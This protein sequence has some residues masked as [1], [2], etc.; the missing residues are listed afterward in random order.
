[1]SMSVAS[2]LVDRHRRAHP[3]IHSDSYT[4][5]HAIVLVSKPGFRSIAI[6]MD[7]RLVM[8]IDSY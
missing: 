3:V 5:S 1:M 6:Y 8:D 2:L 7:M 4:S